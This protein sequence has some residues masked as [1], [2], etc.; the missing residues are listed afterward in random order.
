M[1]LSKAVQ[2]TG[3]LYDYYTVVYGSKPLAA[4]EMPGLMRNFFEARAHGCAELGWLPVGRRTA[5]Q[6]VRYASTFSEFCAKNLGTQSINPLEK[7]LISGLNV[8][9]QMQHY[10]NLNHRKTW[11]MLYHLLPS[12]QQGQGIQTNF[13]FNPLLGYGQQRPNYK[14]F[15]PEKIFELINAT[16]N[17]R[18]KLVFI[19]LFFGGLRLSELYVSDI[20][21]PNGE[22][23]IRIAHPELSTYSWNDKFSG[24]QIGQ[25]SRFLLEHYGSTPR[26]KLGLKNPFHAGW[27]GILYTTNTYEGGFFWLLPGIGNIFAKLHRQYMHETRTNM[28]DN[29]PYYFVNLQEEHYGTPLKASNLSKIF[30]RAAKRVGLLP[31]DS[32]VNPHGARHFYGY[33]C[34]S[35]LKLPID[36]TQCMLRHAKL[37]STQVYYTIDER[38]VRMELQKAYELLNQDLPDFIAQLKSFAYKEH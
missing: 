15:P 3:L 30:Y 11:D 20:T 18:D 8:S 6:D 1:H 16:D 9:E 23:Q 22:A 29:H 27:K 12:T 17:V 10:A 37:S 24:K 28:D 19:L 35:F 26:N 5:K 7:K 21:T 4:N 14:F 36:R 33:F 13:S 32:G 34:A 25:R 38:V 2:A 31:S